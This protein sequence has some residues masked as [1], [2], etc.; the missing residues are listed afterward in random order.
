MM[1]GRCMSGTF[2]NQGRAVQL[3]AT[4]VQLLHQ[5]FNLKNYASNDDGVGYTLQRNESSV[6]L[7]SARYSRRLLIAG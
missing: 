5:E 3:C 1:L 6:R 4:N 2:G 7:I